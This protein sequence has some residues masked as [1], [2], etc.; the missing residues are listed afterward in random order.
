MEMMFMLDWC[1]N[2]RAMGDIA[3][4]LGIRV[5]SQCVRN[6]EFG[7]FLFSCG[8]NNRLIKHYPCRRIQ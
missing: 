7:Q 8:V 6:S 3:S 1:M 5:A 4:D 2:A